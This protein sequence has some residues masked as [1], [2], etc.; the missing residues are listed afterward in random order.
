MTR[1]DASRRCALFVLLAACAHPSPLPPPANARLVEWSELSNIADTC[2]L[3]GP[4]QAKVGE[5]LRLRLRLTNRWADPTPTP[6]IWLTAIDTPL[7]GVHADIFD[8]RHEGTPVPY[9]GESAA[10][11]VHP[12][13]ADRPRPRPPDFESCPTLGC[14]LHEDDYVIIHP[15]ETV[16]GEV[17]LA[18]AYA[19]DRP[20]AYT[21]A[22][23]GWVHDMRIP[24]VRP[25]WE[26]G[27]A[28]GSPPRRKRRLHPVHFGCAAI[29]VTVIGR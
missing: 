16:I 14:I 26:Y 15:S 12:K 1:R 17:D 27:R 20:G 13:D 5:P 6:T 29:S 21:I 24:E 22:W 10:P 23:K 28:S 3:E 25:F 7:H 4:A 18:A 2:R 11:L 19:I 8:I 9:R